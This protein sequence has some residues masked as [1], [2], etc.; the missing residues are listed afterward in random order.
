MILAVW[1]YN[2][3][4]YTRFVRDDGLALAGNV[5][6]CMIL[7]LFPF[8]IFLASLAGFVGDEAM[9]ERAVDYLLSV[10]PE[11]L[12]KAISPEIH[13]LLTAARPD[14]L[15]LAVGFTVWTA[16][17]A[18]ESVRV[19]LNR[20]YG[21]VEHRPYWLRFSQNVAFVL[22][23]AAVLLVLSASVVL[24]PF[25]WGKLVIYFPVMN[26]F[27]GW[28][29]LLAYPVSLVLLSGS[30]VAAHLFLPAKRHRLSEIWPGIL[31]TMA[32]WLATAFGYS[33]YL[34]HFSTFIS[35]Y[36]GLSGII[37]ALTFLYLSG[38]LLIWGGEINQVLIVRNT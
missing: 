26:R 4:A 20:A 36:A 24:G 30:L 5:A 31:L 1:R 22:V 11:Q 8:L 7:A 29:Y 18:V 32:M 14:L 28:F 38:A 27:Y 15:T 12:A 17:G 13:S 37:I 2:R 19:G 21:Y 6:F 33:Y 23:G 34:A 3:D 25:L 35:L 16:S 9:A 10:A